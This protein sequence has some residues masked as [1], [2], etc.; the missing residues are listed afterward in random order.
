M[1]LALGLTLQ[2]LKANFTP[3]IL[4]PKKRSLAVSLNA[5]DLSCRRSK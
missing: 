4:E 2:S 1:E 3:Q 5:L